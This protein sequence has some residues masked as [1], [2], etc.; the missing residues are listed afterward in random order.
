[1]TYCIIKSDHIIILHINKNVGLNIY[2][3]Y[4]FFK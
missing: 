4:I 3:Y 1:M 2:N